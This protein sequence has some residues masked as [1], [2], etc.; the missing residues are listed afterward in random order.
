MN[1]LL[2]GCRPDRFRPSLPCPVTHR[3]PR[4]RGELMGGRGRV[5]FD[6]PNSDYVFAVGADVLET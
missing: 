1:E 5:G 6:I 3:P 4:R 2:A